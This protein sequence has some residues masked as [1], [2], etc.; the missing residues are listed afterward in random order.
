MSLKEFTKEIFTRYGFTEDQINAYLVYLRVPRA[1]TSEVYITLVAENEELK[2]E[3]IVEITDWLVERGFLKRIEGIVPRFI[4]LEPFFEL[5]TKE[6][7]VFR[8]EIAK[9]KDT[10]LTD[11]SN[12][13]EHLEEIQDKSIREVESAVDSQIKAFFEDS[14]SKN[15]NKKNKIDK[16]TIRFSET[17]K[18]LESNIHSIKDKL[19]SNLKDISTNFVS[20]NETAINNIKDDLTGIIENLLS[21]FSTRVENLDRELKTDLDEHVERHK[22]IAN[23]LKPRM[24]QILEKYLERMDKV[25]ADLKERISNL[26]KDHSN[27]VKNT[28]DTLQTN[29]KATVDDRNR[30]LTNQTNDFK[31]MT[32]T[33][34]DNLIEHANRFTDFSEDMAKKGFLWMGKKKKYKARH[35]TTIQNVLKYSKPMKEDFIKACE[36]YI[37]NTRGTTDQIKTDVTE[38]MVNENENLGSIT[39]DLD[40]KAQETIDT[41][42]ETLATDLAGEVDS[43]LQSG[44]KDCSDTTLKL[45]DSLES[46]V[47]QHHREFDNAIN[48]HRDNSL[49]HYT[50][51]DSEIKTKNDSWTREV[52][53][54]F[55]EGKVDC[56]DKIDS[57]IRLWNTEANDLNN[58]LT[59]MLADHKTKYE[60]NAKALQNS[61]SNTTRDTN[62][63]IKDVIADFTLQFMN[64]ID[65]STEMA[66]INEDKLKDIHNASSSIPEI[67]AVTSWQVVGRPAMISAIKDAVYR[68]KSSI[69]IVTP[70][71]VPEILQVVSEYAFQKKA[72]R[73]MLTTF[74]DLEKYG[75]IVK[76][77]RE[78][79]NIQFRQLQS[80][81][82][83]YAVTRDAEE[84]ILAPAT[85]KEAEFISVISNQ[86]GYAKLYSSFIGPIFQAQ[87]RPIR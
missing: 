11:Q 34:I 60:Q 80:K 37:E 5:F 71:V 1:T 81:G 49:K 67:S 87:S 28:T 59:E 25:T 40:Y 8:N 14:D 70:E 54:K 62:Q 68:V 56:T 26:L 82:E 35:Q 41:Q 20:A 24:E 7:E 42:L 66:E 13:F 4:P 6:S 51:F 17:S 78:L 27:H 45:K 73:F 76:K 32:L 83:F 47:K 16:A 2:Y 46:S 65:D 9:I 74:W 53:S 75:G 86:E 3:T 15:S 84:V 29:L 33:L 31:S 48:T 58:N 39:S 44:I 19:N 38:I 57:E 85:E 72:V 64:S 30:T 50:N 55:S 63:T 69:I 12:R 21:D 18:T 52:D 10:I 61:L 36:D 22:T 77:M 23:Q 43:T 79:G